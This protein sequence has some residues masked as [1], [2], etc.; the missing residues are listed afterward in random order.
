MEADIRG[1]FDAVDHGWLIKMLEH[2]IADRKFIEIIRKFLNAGIMENGKYLDSETGT[3]QGNGASP[4]LANIYFH[5]VL[6]NWFD[7]IVQRQCTGECYMVR[8]ADDFVCCF[9]NRYEA[10]IFLERLKERFQKYGLELESS[11]TKILEFGRFAAD[12]AKA[13]GKTKPETF[14]FLGFTFYCST[15]RRKSFFLCKAKTSGKKYRNKLKTMNNWIKQNRNL[16]IQFI[17]SLRRNYSG[18]KKHLQKPQH[19]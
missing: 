5:Y 14:D 13:K 12:K 19:Y 18:K 9:Q 17:I 3:P 10:Q 8:Y 2:D 1:F 7:V 15:D 4:I 6:D 16:P 11:K